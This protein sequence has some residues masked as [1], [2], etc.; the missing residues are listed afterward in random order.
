[1]A[2]VLLL[3]VRAIVSGASQTTSV[4][5]ASAA[6]ATQINSAALAQA[7]SSSL[8]APADA[9]AQAAT[10]TL[11]PTQRKWDTDV[12]GIIN[13]PV[14]TSQLDQALTGV[15]GHVGVAVKDLG[16][17]R[18]A[19]LDGNME[20]QSASLFKLPVLYTV[21]QLGLD[22]SEELT[23]TEDALSYD[24]GTMELGPGE[25]L[26]IAELL[27][28][29][30]TLSD[31]TSAVM[32]GSRV[33]AGNIDANIAA[34]GMTTTHYSVER[35]TTSPLDMLHLMEMIANGQAVSPTASA[36]ML[37]LLLRQR[38]ND[39]L[40][41]LLSDDVQVA[42][43]TGNL[44]GV[45]NDVGILYGPTSTVAVAA[46]VSDTTDETAAATA[47][48]QIGLAANTYFEGQPEVQARPTMLPA[49]SRPIPPVWRQPQPP[50]AV[51]HPAVIVTAVERPAVTTPRSTSV[52]GTPTVATEERL[53]S[54]TPSTA[55]RPTSATPVPAAATVTA[56][57]P[58][59]QAPAA[60]A[61]T[62]TH[63]PAAPPTAAPAMVA[64]PTATPVP[65]PPAPTKAPVSQP[66]VQP[67]AAHPAV[68]ATV[69]PTHH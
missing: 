4:A 39:R 21:F 23:I 11:L 2:L 12:P 42:H 68:G 32:L 29:M 14:L 25:T 38:V 8:A 7:Q 18:G 47:I 49:P 17:G 63:V 3:G 50:T 16:S 19:V 13:D 51:P 61:P 66:T 5:D 48:A 35:M 43:K 15:D 53:G 41:R 46:L 22:M 55:E 44:N 9:T 45:V 56:A 67:T 40:P 26:S 10:A 31:N 30:V 6:A 37:H 33:G 34:L 58:A 20:L 24:S 36:D 69:T 57:K 59:L 62:A 28:R 1:M 60:E 65:A 27:E 54:P 52:G 64:A